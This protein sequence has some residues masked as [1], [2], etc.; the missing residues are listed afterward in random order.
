MASAVRWLDGRRWC[1]A[2][3]LAVAAAGPLAAQPP[4]R[5]D[6]SVAVAGHGA[7]TYV[8]LS[9]LVGGVSGFE[10]L[11][12]RL[13][14]HGH[15]VVAV[16]PYRLSLDSTDVTFAALA[17]RVDAVLVAHDV[18]DA[19]V[20]GHAHGAGVALR[21]AASAP[22]RVATLTFLDVGALR[23]NRTRVFS[24]S[25]RLAPL[26]ARLPGGRGYVRRRFLDGLRENS[27]DHAWLDEPTQRAYT[28]PFLDRIGD[29]VT[30]A[31]RLARAREPEPLAD[32]VAR[33]RAPVTVLLGAEPHPAFPDSAELTALAPLGGRLRVERLPGVGHFPHEEAPEL[34]NAALLAHA[35]A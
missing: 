12:A 3:M 6:A 1:A 9:G 32:V 35:G 15:R 29:V 13:L 17:R 2:A 30:M 33:V 10:R 16:D 8:L 14:A 20:V 26:V 34:V 31:R 28:E 4:A 21:L 25:L 7:T 18:T 24:S 23:E 5:D 27:S 11:R 22:T 19:H